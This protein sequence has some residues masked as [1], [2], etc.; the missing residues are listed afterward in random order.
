[1]SSTSSSSSSMRP[2]ALAAYERFWI[3]MADAALS[4]EMKRRFAKT[5]QDLWSSWAKLKNHMANHEWEPLRAEFGY[6]G[7]QKKG[8]VKKGPPARPRP[9]SEQ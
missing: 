4:R 9:P 3:R 6:K 7:H 8:D 5:L 1:M 2:P